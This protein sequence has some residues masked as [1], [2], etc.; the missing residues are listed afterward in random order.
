MTP[1]QEQI[2]KLTQK[3]E[4]Q[5]EI[6]DYLTKK[7]YGK[8]SEQVDAN[9]L[10]LLE[11]DDGVFTEPEQTGQEN[12]ANQVQSAKK[13]KKTRQEVLSPNLPVK[14]TI[15]DVEDK[16]CPHGHRLIFVGEKF[17]REQLHFQPAKLYREEIY[18]HTYKCMDCE[19]VDG[20][21]RLIQGLVPKPVI[22][23][24]LGSASVIA[25]IIHQKF[26]QGVPL[27]RQ[28][29]EWQRMGA[30][31]SETTLANWV[32]KSG[33][34]MTP[35]YNLIRE[36]LV[37]QPY[38]QG[39][40]T[41]MQV[42]REPGKAATSKSYMW[43]M[44]SVRK[45]SKQAVLYAYS[46]TRSG[47]FA[48]NLY[49]GFTGVLQC[50]GYAGYNGLDRSVIRVGCFAHVRRKFYEA[51]SVNGKIVMSRPLK[52]LDEMFALEK[53][54][55]Q[56]SP[57]SRRRQRQRLLL[58]LVRKFWSWI[59]QVD[60]LPKSRLGKAI[61][62]ARNQRVA[63]N[64][65]L[66]YGAIDFSNNASERNMKSF[67]IGRKNWLFST[68]L[69]GAEATAI[70]MTLIESAKANGINPRDYVTYLLNKV[71]QLPDF[72]KKEDLE[73]YLPWNYQSKLESHEEFNA[74]A[75]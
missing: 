35:L 64:R 55:K 14:K 68:S 5:A 33:E 19:A 63:L 30:Q 59:D 71:P 54:W 66:N 36:E 42:L 67:V 53:E 74:I 60:E 13:R 49:R 69:A 56:W 22:P 7:L 4:E 17:I 12:Q 15:I 48:E 62:Y 50:D 9:Q 38:L 34:M 52:L 26:E 21:A 20:L 1:E 57:R 72:A 11:E 18:T 51:A 27:S 2:A 70:W 37:A 6:I 45:S 39:D 3:V 40:E 61:T 75:A 31:L 28:L 46:D 24:S 47:A 23:H 41:P 25:E 65:V 58:K 44:R 8:K 73:A 10:S 43:V 32:I 29:K 16:Q